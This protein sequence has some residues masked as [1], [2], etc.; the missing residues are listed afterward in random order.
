MCNALR[1]HVGFTLHDGSLDSYSRRQG[2]G[3]EIERNVS[4]V[5]HDVSTSS[6]SGSNTGPLIYWGQRNSFFFDKI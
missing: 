1:V 2:L 5:S 4:L 3:I 6:P